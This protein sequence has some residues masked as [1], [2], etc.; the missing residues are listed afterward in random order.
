VAAPGELKLFML[1]RCLVGDQ[2]DLLPLTVFQF[3]HLEIIQ[4]EVLLILSP[5]DKES[6][7]DQTTSHA[8]PSSQLLAFDLEV[9][10]A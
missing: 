10:P 1:L 6:V 4:V 3:Q 8:L 2:R 9:F 5:M 7:S